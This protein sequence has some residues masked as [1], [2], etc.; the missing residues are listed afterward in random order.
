MKEVPGR[1]REAGLSVSEY[2]YWRLPSPG[3]WGFE[4]PREGQR[5]KEV[6]KHGAAAA[7]A[8]LTCCEITIAVSYV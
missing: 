7:T 6:D 5:L 8:Q 3:T 1:S 2:A 4:G